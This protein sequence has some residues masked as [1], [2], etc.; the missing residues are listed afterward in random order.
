M[1]ESITDLPSAL[2]WYVFLA[3]QPGW[4]AYVWDRVNEMASDSSGLWNDL[5]S[6]L[7]KEM[8]EPASD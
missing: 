6:L 4:K 3:K 1:E 2:Q 7:V 8:K 5:P